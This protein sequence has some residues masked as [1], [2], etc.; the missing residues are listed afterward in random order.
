MR[1]G[2]LLRRDRFSQ[3][4]NLRHDWLDL[5]GIDQLRNLSE[6]VGIRMS[7]DPGRGFRVSEARP[8]R[9]ARPAT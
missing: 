2:L 6:I 1:R 4:K 5:P 3:R 7:G 8:D 9:E